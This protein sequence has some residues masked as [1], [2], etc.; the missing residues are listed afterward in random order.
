MAET[1][2]G[3]LTLGSRVARVGK[4]GSSAIAV[5]DVLEHHGDHILVLNEEHKEKLIL[6]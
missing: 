3:I 6:A 4:R 5:L 2:S 1:A